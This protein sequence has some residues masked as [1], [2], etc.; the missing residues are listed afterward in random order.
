MRPGGRNSTGSGATKARSRRRPSAR[1]ARLWEAAGGRLLHQAA[2]RGEV[3]AAAF[4]P[5]GQTFLTAGTEKVAQIWKTATCQ[6]V[7]PL[8]LQAPTR[9]GAFS[10]DGRTLVVARPDA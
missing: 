7:Q 9:V 6:H 5:D 1:T 2:S 3:Q 8:A 10:P 4:T